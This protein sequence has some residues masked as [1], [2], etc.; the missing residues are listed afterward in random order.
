[1]HYSIKWTGRPQLNNF[2]LGTDI[3]IFLTDLRPWCFLQSCGQ[4]LSLKRPDFQIHA[5]KCQ[6]T[7]GLKGVKG[8]CK[9]ESHR[10]QVRLR[11]RFCDLNVI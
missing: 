9:R 11:P 1:M 6:V 4:A 5:F 7:S 2:R 10:I 8:Q 3:Y